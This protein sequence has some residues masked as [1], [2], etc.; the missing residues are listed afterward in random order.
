MAKVNWRGLTAVIVPLGVSTMVASSAS[1]DVLFEFVPGSTTFTQSGSDAGIA[2]GHP[3]LSLSFRLPVDPAIG[4]AGRAAQAPRIA[5]V[6]LPA[7]L[8]GDP[9]ATKTCPLDDVVAME[10]AAGAGR[11]DREAAVGVVKLVATYP[12]GNNIIPMERR[13]WRLPSSPNE[14]AAFGTS[15]V[16]VPIRISVTV[17][18]SG[19]YRV[20]AAGTQLP[21]SAFVNGFTVSLWG[22]P[23]DH[24]GAG[25]LC[26]GQFL[27]A[28][29]STK[30]CLD[31]KLQG[32][33]AVNQLMTFG[34]S[35]GGVTRKPFL[36]NPS[37]CGASLDATWRLVPYG[38]VF[39]PIEATMNAGT[40]NG[41]ENQPFDPSIDVTPVSKRAG[42]PSGVTVGINVPQNDDPDGVGAA[43]VKD[44]SVSLPEGV[45]ISPPSGNG[46]DACSDAQLDLR[47]DSDPACPDASKIGSLKIETPVL[48]EPVT[49]TAFLGTQLSKDPASGEM[50]R[51]FLVA[52]SRGVLIKLKGAVKA[53]PKTG[54]LTTVFENNPQLPFSRMELTLD[55]GDRASLSLPKAC[56]AY[57]STAKITSYAGHSRD[58]SSSF[59]I[60]EGCPDGRFAPS[61]T[62]GTSNPLAGAF[63]P[64]SMTVSRSDADQDLSRLN[65]ELPSGLLAALGSVPLCGEA[66]ANV[67]TCSAASRIGATNVLVGSGGQPLPLSGQVFVTGPYKGAPFGLS[68]VVPAKVGPFD[69]GDVVVRG[70]LQVDANNAKATAVTDA[71]PTIVGGVPVR[72][73]QVNVSLDRPG[74]TFNATSC[75]QQTVRGA[76]WSTAGA[77]SVVGT[78]YQAQG[79]DQL[80]L[81]PRLSLQ[82]TGR[83]QMKKGKHPGLKAQLGDL[84]GQA[85]LKKVKVTL[86][87]TAALD[88]KNAKALCEPPQAAAR[89]CP[90][91]SIIGQAS[92]STPALHTGRE[93]GTLPKLWIP[94]SGEGVTVDLWANSDVDSKKRLVSTFA[95][96]PDVPVRDFQLELN[97]GSNG[98]L[99]AT[100]D[101]CSASKTTTIEYAGHNGG[102]TL[103]RIAMTAPDCGRQI[104]GAAN[105]KN[106]TVGVRVA[107]I[108]PGTLTITGSGIGKATRK[109]VRSDTALI[110]ASLTKNGRRHL[111]SGKALR[112]RLSVR[113]TPA[114]GKSSTVRKTVTI[115]PV[116]AKASQR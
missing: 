65:L 49:G 70:Q 23:A 113:F 21:Q 44:V 37:V 69:L 90:A 111:R 95:N 35:L 78:P 74:F 116:K 79:C 24:Q 25:P 83:S 92:A 41:C 101:V 104:V 9:T 96:V 42:Q 19:G 88:P 45:A 91:D 10:K 43:H 56:G 20:R 16:S 62:A 1:A 52:K 114:K 13:L 7:G 67:G 68:V 38:T 81:Q 100:N 14:V 105:S 99:K 11:C 89:N 60:D 40:I 27:G 50:Y 26:D 106:R 63:S 110:R 4:V 57:T 22:V 82:W 59:L 12:A 112:T 77:S 102:T 29:G 73:R 115:K 6:T 3:D 2:G 86:P 61:L 34:G 64:F 97:G 46:L 5:G 28:G 103:Q 72:L 8:I 47:G 39:Q 33:P 17:T 93:I 51:L 107:G 109:V 66:E 15:I 98:I 108:G 18:P 53:D 31:N 85:N 32:L 36:T 54:Q 94:L 58:L 30:Y 84:S 48:D 71:F 87:L 55:D 76:F 75:A 80:K